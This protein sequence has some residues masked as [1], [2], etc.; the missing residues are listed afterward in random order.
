GLFDLA[1]TTVTNTASSLLV[2]YGAT[3]APGTAT[4]AMTLYR[5]ASG[6]LVFSAGTVHWSWGLNGKHDIAT[7]T[8]DPTMQQ[9][10]VNLLADMGVQ[11]ATLQSGLIPAAASADHAPPTSTITYPTNG[12][13]LTPGVPITIAGTAQ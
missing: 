12:L 5:A 4:W 8:P 10:T 7:T 1:T 13:V 2:D 9:A 3:Y 11:P 6:A